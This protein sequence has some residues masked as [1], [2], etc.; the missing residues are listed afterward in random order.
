MIYCQASKLLSSSW[1][2]CIGQHSSALWSSWASESNSKHYRAHPW[3]LDFPDAFLGLRHCMIE[4]A[5]NGTHSALLF[6]LSVFSSGEPA[7]VRWRRPDHL[8]CTPKTE[9]RREKQGK[10]TNLMFDRLMNGLLGLCSLIK[11]CCCRHE[12]TNHYKKTKWWQ[13]M[14]KCLRFT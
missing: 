14:H 12:T 2:K 6:N 11:L 7:G 4:G 3:L 10:R 8:G 9:G 5:A 1:A 13:T